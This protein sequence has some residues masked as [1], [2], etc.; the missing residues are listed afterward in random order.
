M[1][2]HRSY[3]EPIE[4]GGGLPT[5]V[6]PK[7]T[8]ELLRAEPFQF[9]PVDPHSEQL[10]GNADRDHKAMKSIHVSDILIRCPITGRAVPTGLNTQTIK[11]ESLL[12]VEVGLQCQWCGQQ[13]LWRPRDAWLASP[14]DKTCH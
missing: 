10:G 5:P 6:V 11:F 3:I 7:D 1:H 4:I 12:D 14:A 9:E 2:I 8:P 13:H